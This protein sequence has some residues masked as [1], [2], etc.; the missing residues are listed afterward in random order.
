MADAGEIASKGNPLEHLAL[1]ENKWYRADDAFDRSVVAI[2]GAAEEYQ[3][4]DPAIEEV[5]C[6]SERRERKSVQRGPC[7]K[8]SEYAV[9]RCH[10]SF[11]FRSPGLRTRA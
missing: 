5:S 3:S 7:R 6:R 4:E 11:A 2:G 1:T 8:H 9:R 10:A